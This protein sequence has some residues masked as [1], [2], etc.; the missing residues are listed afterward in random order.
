M[1][2]NSSHTGLYRPQ[3]ARDSCGFGLIAHM[4]GEASHELVAT[5]CNAL[6]RMTHRGAVDADGKT[7]DGCG[8]LMAFPQ[9]FF[10]AVAEEQ[11]MRLEDHFAV[12]MVFLSQDPEIAERSRKILEKRI[13]NETL[14][15]AGWR[16]VPLDHA[17]LGKVAAES[18]PRVEQVFVNAPFGWGQHDIERRLFVARRLASAENARLEA[19]DRSFHIATLSNMVTVY[20]GLVM[21]GNLPQFFPDLSDER[22]TSHICLFHQRFSTNTLPEWKYAQPF[23]F[24]AHNGEIN[25]IAGNR[26]WSEARTPKFA[27]PLLPDLQN[28]RPLVNQEGSDSSSLDK[29][30]ELFLAGGMDVFRAMRILVP[31]AWQAEPDMSPDLKA[32]YEFNSQ[33]VEPWDGPAGIVMTNGSIAACNLDRNGLRPARYVITDNNWLTLASEVGVWDYA[34]SSVLEKGRVGP[35]EMFAVDTSS[36]KL[37]R[38]REIDDHL[39]ARRPYADWLTENVVRIHNNDEQEAAAAAQY[40][41]DG[42][43]MLPIYQK[44]YGVTNEEREQVIRV[45]AAESVEATGSMGD[46]TPMA[47]MSRQPRALYDYFR[48]QFAQ[49]T[50]PPIDPLREQSSMSL[51][52]IFGR[53]HNVFLETTTHAHRVL[54]PWPVLNIVKYRRLLELSE[55][56]YRHEIFSLNFALDGDLETA[57]QQL[58]DR[59]VEAVSRGVVIVV[60]TDRHVSPDALPIP[61]VLAVGAVHQRLIREGL[62]CDCNLVVETG[63]ARDSHQFAVLLG[64]GATAIYPYLA[65][66]IINDLF[67]RGA[68]TGDLLQHRKFYRR[69]VR[70]GLLKILSKMGISCVASYRGAQLFETV[71]LASEV[72]ELCFPGAS[73]QVGGASFAHVED[74]LRQLHALAW[75]QGVPVA[76]GGLLKFTHGGEYHAYNPDVVLGLQKAVVS[77][78]AS[79][80]REFA[81]RV[82]HRPPA[83]LRDLLKLRYPPEALPLEQVE[84]AERLFPRFDSAAMSIG[85]LSPEAHEALAVAMNRLGGNSNSGEGGEDPDRFGTERN[86][87][88]KQVASGRFGVTAHYLVNADI[89]QIKIAQ[90]AKPGEGGQLPG[91][92]VTALIAALRHAVPGVTL[93]SPP[94][95]H[96]IYSIEDLAQLIFDLKQVNPQA[97]ISVKLVSQRGVGTI[98]AG[99]AKAYADCI[100][101]AGHDGGTGASPLTSVKYAGSPWETGLAEVHQAL[102]ENG[103][104]ER[105]RLQV[106]GG[107]KT[108]LDVIKGAILGADSFGFGTG[109]MVALGCKYLRI[110]H[111]NNCATGVATQ[112]EQLRRE[113][114]QGLPERVMTYFRFIAEEVREYLSRLGFES[115]DQIVGRSDLLERITAEDNPSLTPKQQA[116]D[117]APVLASAAAAGPA[118]L[119]GYRD[120]RN[121]PHDRGHLNQSIVKA[122]EAGV[123]SGQGSRHTFAISNRDRSVGAAL[124]GEIARTH[125]RDGLPGQAFELEFTGSAGQSFGV[126]NH[127][128]MNLS[129]AGDANDYVGK[130]MGGGRIA[131]A[132]H[133]EAHIVA[134]RSTI[135]G[136]TCLYGATGGELF[137]AGQAGE[138]FAVRNS[139]ATAVVEGLGHHGCEYMT[140]GL[141]VVL[142]KVGPNFAAGMTGGRA[143]VLDMDERFAKRCNSDSVIVNNLDAW[144][145]SRDTELIKN[146]LQRHRQFTGS[147]WAARLLEDFDHFAY[148]FRVVTPRREPEAAA[149]VA[150]IKLV[151]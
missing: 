4:Q 90:G 140:G 151:K 110:C 149:S 128:G 115:L 74:D 130:G 85:A 119:A 1:P 20:K 117:L 81:D 126:W 106:D 53:E 11:N 68:L 51:A 39:K 95:H 45:M 42:S 40:L 25:T 79:D 127:H 32:F 89:L 48:Q 37:W 103:L 63:T 99:V 10:R 70:K 22:L 142:G 30:L 46:D 6:D 41:R 62:R 55:R 18:L 3:D 12:G 82:N 122:C 101:I 123:Q 27:T 141:V 43:Q 92:K 16:E 50:N 72:T 143:F 61:A 60:L 80:Y 131:I 104:R 150:P 71:G 19:P 137:A 118:Q 100:T 88:I 23:R 84:P 97:L 121:A 139:G 35:G 78:L 109:P 65:F 33:H 113:H 24:L 75:K 93:I 124:A 77:G 31:P 120:I 94:P 52:T 7:G 56:W 134:K 108:G 59:V 8:I 49:V 5:A 57:L 102:V 116:I 111:L 129:L 29:M 136:N 125:G 73:G 86:S 107:L 133:P 47:V 96:D 69:G 58:C 83:A 66:Q 13:R 54:L 146:L 17:V 9:A 87:R 145:H 2:L 67:K 144:D 132:P 26:S 64:V 28:I 91:K 98:A 114:F 14:S 15:V 44:L 148:Y 138:R 112:D 38:S 34:E 135:M 36:G 76:Q 105:I 21:P 147:V